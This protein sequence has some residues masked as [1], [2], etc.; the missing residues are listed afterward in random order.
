MRNFLILL[1]LSLWFGVFSAQAKTVTDITGRQ[2]VVPDNPQRI[3]VGESRMLYTL[4]L[5]EPGNPAQRIVGWPADLAR[6]RC[7][8]LAAL[9]AA[10]SADSPDPRHQRQ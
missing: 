1:L 5:L 8:K 3:V 4:A 7:A 2:V 6:F 10:V 9:Y